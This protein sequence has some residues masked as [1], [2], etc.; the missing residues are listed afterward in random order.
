MRAR[1]KPWNSPASSSAFDFRFG[2]CRNNK[3]GD[4]HRQNAP[5]NDFDLIGILVPL[6]EISKYQIEPRALALVRALD[7]SRSQSE[8]RQ[9]FGKKLVDQT[10][11][12]L[13][14]WG[15]LGTVR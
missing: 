6:S 1:L 3:P 12:I 2:L 11:E 9:T 8:F 5:T 13:G 10:L 15:F 7:G 14:R 4:C